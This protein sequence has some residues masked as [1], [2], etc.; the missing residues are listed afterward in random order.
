MER[1]YRKHSSSSYH[2]SAGQDSYYREDDAAYNEAS[3]EIPEPSRRNIG[4]RMWGNDYFKSYEKIKERE[5]AKEKSEPFYEY[6]QLVPNPDFFQPHVEFG[7]SHDAEA[8]NEQVERLQKQRM[9]EQ[10]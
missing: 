10:R 4:R 9:Q 2:S 6:L 5:V 1:I 7:D 8:S 3:R